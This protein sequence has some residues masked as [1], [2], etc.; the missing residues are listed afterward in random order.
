MKMSYNEND[1]LRLIYRE[2]TEAESKAIRAAMVADFA[3]SE[4]YRQLEKIHDVLDEGFR[5][6]NQSSID[7]IMEHSRNTT[8][9][10]TY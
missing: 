2:T 3:L 9:L 7:L 10:E 5:N 4:R 6:P 8:P 1:L